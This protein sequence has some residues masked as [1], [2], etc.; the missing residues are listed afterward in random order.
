MMR[1]KALTSVH[2]HYA[3]GFDTQTLAQMLDSLVRVTRRAASNHYANILQ[4][5]ILSLLW[6][7]SSKSYNT[8]ERATFSM[9]LSNPRN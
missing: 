7:Y 5:A 8:P 1:N 2:F 6:L 3:S 9:I 4:K